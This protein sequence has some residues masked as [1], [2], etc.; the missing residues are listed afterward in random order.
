MPEE[1]THDASGDGGVATAR[2]TL[3]VTDNRTGKSYEL[4]VKNGTIRAMDLRGIKTDDEDFGL[5]VVEVIF[6]EHGALIGD[7]RHQFLVDRRGGDPFQ[8]LV[9]LQRQSL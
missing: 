8:A 9:L 7:P 3:S 1:Q 2:D 6:Q 5:I 4:E